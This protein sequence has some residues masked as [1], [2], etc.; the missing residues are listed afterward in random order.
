MSHVGTFPGCEIDSFPPAFVSEK[1]SRT[2]AI[3][4]TVDD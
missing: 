3:E 2:S 4:G 1:T